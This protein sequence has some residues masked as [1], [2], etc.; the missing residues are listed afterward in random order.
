MLQAKNKYAVAGAVALLALGF[1]GSRAA[2]GAR[3]KAPV[4]TVGARALHVPH[5][6]GNLVLDGDL[7]DSAWAASDVARTGQFLD[8]SGGP[9]RPH[10]E[11]RLVW[12]D[13]HLY[14]A[15]YAADEDVRALPRK[16]DEAVWLDDSFRVVFRRG[17]VEMA[18]DVS[19][20]GVIT[21]AR[22]VRG[23]SPDYSWD[24]G[25]HVSTELD[26][27]LNDPR[28]DDEEWALE[29]AIPFESLGMRGARGESIAVSIQRCDTP[30]GAA[31]TCA[32]W[33]EGIVLD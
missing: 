17:D 32:T 9:A 10:S 12:G 33:A 20:T 4:T 24:S 29:L 23:G 2:S 1:L 16:P 18:F 11:A 7:D 8:A 15:L 14:M 27:T 26:G 21:D 30:K 13:G 19:A 25:A 31:R 28:D 3:V 5:L 6:R 22:R